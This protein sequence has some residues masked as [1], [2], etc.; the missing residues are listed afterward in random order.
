MVVIRGVNFYPTAV[1]MVLRRVSE[2]AEYQVIQSTRDSMAELEVVVEPQAGG[3]IPASELSSRIARALHSAFALRIPVRS[4]DP[5]T[6]PK[7]EF[8]SRRWIKQ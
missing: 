4:V 7:A 8:K 5:G 1:E 3:T 2:L 6:L